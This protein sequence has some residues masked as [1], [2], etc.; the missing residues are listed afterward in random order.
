MPPHH[1]DE[2]GINVQ[3]YVQSITGESVEIREYQ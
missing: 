3:R 2:N 1:E